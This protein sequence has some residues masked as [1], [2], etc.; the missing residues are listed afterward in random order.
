MKL[1]LIQNI[2]AVQQLHY[3]L[4]QRCKPQQEISSIHINEIKTKSP[5]LCLSFFNNT[6]MLIVVIIMIYIL[7]DSY[8]NKQELYDKR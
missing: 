7:I 2:F 4:P 5:I 3:S 1:D 6:Y 8:F